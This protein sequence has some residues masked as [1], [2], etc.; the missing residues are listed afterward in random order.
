MCNKE[1]VESMGLYARSVVLD[2]KNMTDNL[3]EYQDWIEY[4]LNV[5]DK[6]REKII[7]DNGVDVESFEYGVAVGLGRAIEIILGVEEE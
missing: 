6:A 3:E 5:I 4:C 1:G 2:R 7:K